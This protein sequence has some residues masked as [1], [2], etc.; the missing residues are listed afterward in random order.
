MDFTIVGSYFAIWM[1]SIPCYEE[2]IILSR[3]CPKSHCYN[4]PKFIRNIFCPALEI[5]I[6]EIIFLVWQFHIQHATWRSANEIKIAF[7]H[8]Q[9]KSFQSSSGGGPVGAADLWSEPKVFG[10]RAEFRLV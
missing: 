5:V 4:V 7:D 10:P 9:I 8:R 1:T 3:L 6:L 2:Q